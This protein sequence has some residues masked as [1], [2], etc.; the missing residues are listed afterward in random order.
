MD[1]S[2]LR[3]LKSN[4]RLNLVFNRGVGWETMQT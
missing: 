2:L 1:A 4:V 3:D